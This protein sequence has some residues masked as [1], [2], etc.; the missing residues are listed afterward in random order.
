VWEQRLNQLSEAD[1]KRVVQFCDDGMTSRAIA[2][3]LSVSDATVSRILDEAGKR[4][5]RGEFGVR[6]GYNEV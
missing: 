5:K 1:R 2:K 4:P 3:R 6:I